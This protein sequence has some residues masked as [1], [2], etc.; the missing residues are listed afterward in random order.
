M[1]RVDPTIRI[2]QISGVLSNF[3]W[4][5]VKQTITEQDVTLVITKVLLPPPDDRDHGAD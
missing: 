2:Q 3:G 5:V 4:K 1:P